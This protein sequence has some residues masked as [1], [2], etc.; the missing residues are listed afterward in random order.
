MLRFMMVVFFNF[1]TSAEEVILDVGGGSVPPLK[2]ISRNSTFFVRSLC[3]DVLDA[4]LACLTSHQPRID[5]R[6]FGL[7]F[8]VTNEMSLESTCGL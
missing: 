1:V 7:V 4:K 2:F 5:R 8:R 6:P 3:E